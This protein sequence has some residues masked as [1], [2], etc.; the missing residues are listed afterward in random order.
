MG[1][2]Q[3]IEEWV[4][5]HEL[6]VGD[7]E[8]STV[9]LVVRSLLNTLPREVDEVEAELSGVDFN[10]FVVGAARY[11]S[12][13]N[14]RLLRL[15]GDAAVI[16]AA[17]LSGSPAETGLVAVLNAFSIAINMARSD[18][19]SAPRV[20]RVIS[21]KLAHLGDDARAAYT[22][23]LVFRACN[24]AMG[25]AGSRPVAHP[26]VVVEA[27]NVLGERLA[28]LGEAFRESGFMIDVD[29]EKRWLYGG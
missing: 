3:L 19:R 2:D 14:R 18:A 15:A 26:Y 23:L 4:L 29:L 22:A 16:T 6:R 5:R 10:G 17:A 20:Q 13:L 11:A 7:A 9:R 21:K 24:A 28:V 12:G 8:R 27:Y 1:F 25:A